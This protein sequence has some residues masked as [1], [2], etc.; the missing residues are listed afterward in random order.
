[1]TISVATPATATAPC[2]PAATTRST[3]SS[4]DGPAVRVS[5][6][7]IKGFSSFR[8]GGSIAAAAATG[9]AALMQR[10]LAQF[11]D[12]ACGHGLAV[13]APRGADIRHDGGGFG[14]VQLLRERRHAVGLR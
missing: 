11:I 10:R 8:C 6:A 12:F 1:M 4:V 5:F 3:S 9:H 7:S 13:I 14:V 2:G